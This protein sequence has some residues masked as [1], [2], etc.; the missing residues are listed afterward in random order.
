MLNPYTHSGKMVVRVYAT[1]TECME[2]ARHA[3]DVVGYESAS[4]IVLLNERNA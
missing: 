2:G 3:V 4:C 1:P